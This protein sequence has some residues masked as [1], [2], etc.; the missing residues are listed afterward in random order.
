V[1]V[2]LEEQSGDLEVAMVEDLD[3]NFLD[4]TKKELA[5]RREAHH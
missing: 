3:W 1:V 2:G 4:N 5:T